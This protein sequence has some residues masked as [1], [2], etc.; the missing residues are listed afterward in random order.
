MGPNGLTDRM[1]DSVTALANSLPEHF[2]NPNQLPP[3]ADRQVPL[4]LFNTHP[5]APD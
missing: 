1:D 3:D 4:P 2:G 5:A